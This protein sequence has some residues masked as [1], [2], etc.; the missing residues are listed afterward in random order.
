MRKLFFLICL[1]P[2]VHT[3]LG[4][5]YLFPMNRDMHTRIGRHLAS[6]TSGFH[7]SIFPYAVTDLDSVVDPDTVLCAKLGDSKFYSTWFGR[8]LRKENLFVVNADDL[9]LSIDPVFNLQLGNETEAGR[10]VYVNTRGVWVQGNV[11]NRFFF[12]TAFH[13]NQ[14]RYIGYVDSLI[15]KDTVVPGQGKVKFIEDESFDFSMAT[16]GMAFRLN[17]HFEF[18]L[19]QDKM[20]IGD[21]Y[22]SMLLSDNGYPFPFLR[23]N[24]TFWKFRYS[25]TYAV[26]Q[27]LRSPH[28]ENVG[29]AKKY[30]TFHYLDLNIGKRNKVTL[31]IFEA[32]VW[33]Q[34]PSRGYELH[35]LNPFLFLRPVE[36]SLDSPDNALLGLNARWKINGKNILYGQLML[37]EFL[38]DEVRA[39]D[40]WWGNKQA[41]QL[42]LKSFDLFRVKSLNFQTEVNFARPFTYQHRSNSQDYT[43]YNQ[44]LAHPLGADFVESVSFINYRWN[45][46]FA[47]FRLQLAQ[48]GKDTA[49]VNLGNDIF[50]SYETRPQDYGYNMFTGLKSN[51]SSLGLR[52]N[53]LVNHRTNFIVEAGAELRRFEN[54]VDNQ[55]SRF[56]YF[57]IRTSL[58]NYY[59][60]F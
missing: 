8:K 48:T 17:K 56:F 29:Y 41:F 37:D 28:D 55:Q 50:K 58:E 5:E 39:G 40:G 51:L 38:I 26:M 32:V 2:L 52:V 14:A 24:M 47:E 54:E 19:A 15:R 53:Y 33:K 36:N 21:G 25:V 30:S 49:G 6:D 20:F 9:K 3:A 4:Q 13:E 34:D 16:G 46:L 57:G 7:T 10:N 35:Y 1:L 18:L 31:G 22:R 42:G 23:A 43:H 11:S 45:N 60:D 27:D 44:P 59:F 12:Y